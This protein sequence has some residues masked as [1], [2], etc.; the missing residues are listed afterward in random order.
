M[1]LDMTID[2]TSHLLGHNGPGAW[3]APRAFAGSML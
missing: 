1:T 3:S 2:G